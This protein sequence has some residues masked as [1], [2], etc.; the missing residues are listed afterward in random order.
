MN[1]FYRKGPNRPSS[2]PQKK[3]QKSDKIPPPFQARQLLPRLSGYAAH[4]KRIQSPLKDHRQSYPHQLPVF[5]LRQ[6]VSTTANKLIDD[7]R[8]FPQQG[9][10]IKNSPAILSKS[11]TET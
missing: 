2:T 8:F 11:Y 4:D 9:G 6:A 1:K 7:E 3:T 10:S 5:P